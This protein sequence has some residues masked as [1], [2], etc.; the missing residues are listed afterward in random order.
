MQSA[1]AP[2]HKSSTRSGES[3]QRVRAAGE[4]DRAFVSLTVPQQPSEQVRV[5]VILS[6]L[7][8]LGRV[9]AVSDRELVRRGFSERAALH[10]VG[11]RRC[12]LGLSLLRVFASFGFHG[13]HRRKPQ[14]VWLA[15]LLDV[16][17]NLLIKRDQTLKASN[18]LRP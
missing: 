3:E 17:I 7:I 11:V 8:L 2:T 16:R 10:G 15:E 12:Q 5:A 13:Q 18:H 6:I 1:T 4:G 14:N 9:Q